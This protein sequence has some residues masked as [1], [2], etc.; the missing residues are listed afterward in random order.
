[1]ST[2]YD[3]EA[4]K[5]K[6]P[7]AIEELQQ[8][9]TQYIPSMQDRARECA[10]EV[11]AQQVIDDVEAMCI[12]FDGVIDLLKQILGEE[13]DSVTT[14]SMYG[15]LHYAKQTDSILNGV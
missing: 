1:M 13:G 3:L 7:P 8:L 10:K 11:G 2:T 14:G 5:A 4:A 9:I 12:T 15:A 6:I